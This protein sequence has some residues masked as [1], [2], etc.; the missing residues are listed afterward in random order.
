MIRNAT[1]Y[2]DDGIMSA[3]SKS[4]TTVL[5]QDDPQR[6]GTSLTVQ[7][8]L[9]GKVG[10]HTIGDGSIM[11]HTSSAGPDMMD[12]AP[13]MPIGEEQKSN[14]FVQSRRHLLYWSR[15]RW[16][17]QVFSLEPT[18]KWAVQCLLLDYFACSDDLFLPRQDL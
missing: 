16:V 13:S 10:D 18:M 6:T 3:S 12:I 8:D 1:S 14:R 2:Q 9:I 4:G 15:K 17:D 11:S 7:E 5:T